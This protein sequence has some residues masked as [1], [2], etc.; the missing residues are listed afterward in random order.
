MGGEVWLRRPRAV[1][2]KRAHI[3]L[4]MSAF[5]YQKSNYD[6]TGS[7][8][9]RGGSPSRNRFGRS[10]KGRTMVWRDVYSPN[11]HSHTAYEQAYPVQL[12]AE[13]I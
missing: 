11:H 13:L 9:C 2:C 5:P 7:L 4:N 8:P 10:S 1:K 6:D 12:I 3:E